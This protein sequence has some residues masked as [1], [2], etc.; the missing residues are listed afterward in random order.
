VW[1]VVTQAGEEAWPHRFRETV[2]ARVVKRH[3]Q[4]I[5]SLFA[6]KRRLDL[7]KMDTAMRYIDRYVGEK[8]ELSAPLNL[9]TSEELPL[10]RPLTR[11]ARV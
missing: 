6:V 7:E 1:R 9:A 8:M 2:G 3:G 5:V 10:E 11:N 4:T